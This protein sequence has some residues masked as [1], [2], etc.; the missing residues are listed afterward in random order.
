MAPAA[1]KSEFNQELYVPL[2][3]N[4]EQKVD[5]FVGEMNFMKDQ[6]IWGKE[7]TPTYTIKD[8]REIRQDI[9]PERMPLY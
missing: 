4:S 7:V 8:I 1:V 2:S 3:R 5:V 6:G 9:W